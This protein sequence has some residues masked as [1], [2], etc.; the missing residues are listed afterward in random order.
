[1]EV[2]TWENE[3]ALWIDNNMKEKVWSLQGATG[4]AKL[5]P[6]SWQ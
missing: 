2:L 5:D 4:S 3:E 1:M 6:W